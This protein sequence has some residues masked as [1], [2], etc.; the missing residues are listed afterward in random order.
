MRFPVSNI[1]NY[2]SLQHIAI[3][4]F[5]RYHIKYI[6]VGNIIKNE[7]EAII[8]RLRPLLQ[9]RLRFITHLNLEDIHTE[10]VYAF[11]R[12]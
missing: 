4:L 2:N 1:R 3:Y 9:M 12:T 7:S 5:F 11:L 10:K 8:K 6:H